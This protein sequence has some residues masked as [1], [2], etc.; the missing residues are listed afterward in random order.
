VDCGKVKEREYD[1]MTGV[2]R[3]TVNWVS[4]AS[5]DQRSGRAG[6]TGPGHAYRL[7]SS[8]VF[9]DQFEQFS[10]PEI[11]RMPMEGIVLSMKNMHLD[12]VVNF[13]F[14]TCP[15][16][17]ALDKAQKLLV[18]LGAL[19]GDKH[20]RITEVGQT[21]ALFPVAP[22]FAKMYTVYDVVM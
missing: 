4:K 16:R 19:N 11:L 15:E 5:A 14:P 8:A 7:Y 10:T 12:N 9:N 21:M 13:P 17:S 18:S 6:R 2:Q 22:R 1:P 20:A 3:F